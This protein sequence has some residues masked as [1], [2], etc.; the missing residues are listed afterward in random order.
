LALRARQ[1]RIN[2]LDEERHG[3]GIERRRVLSLDGRVE[4]S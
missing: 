1:Q 2:E 4:F 3:R